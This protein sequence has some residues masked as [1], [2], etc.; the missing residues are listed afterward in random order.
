M[1]IVNCKSSSS[2]TLDLTSRDRYQLQLGILLESRGINVSLPIGRLWA[3]ILLNKRLLHLSQSD[4][5]F[6]K[7]AK[8]ITFCKGKDMSADTQDKLLSPE[9]HVHQYM[10]SIIA[11]VDMSEQ[12]RT[13]L[14]EATVG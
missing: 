11:T 7:I 8:K 3:T 9:Q 4:A 2:V 10:R 6:S 1:F 5:W 13:A 14:F 12:S